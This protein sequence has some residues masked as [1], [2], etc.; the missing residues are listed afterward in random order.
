MKVLLKKVMAKSG[1]GCRFHDLNYLE[2]GL[3]FIFLELILNL[4]AFLQTLFTI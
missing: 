4:K 2:V 1:V 3:F